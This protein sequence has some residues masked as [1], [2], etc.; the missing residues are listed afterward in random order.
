[1]LVGLV[2]LT[3]TVWVF[4][5]ALHTAVSG[6]ARH[7]GGG[8]AQAAIPPLGLGTPGAGQAGPGAGSG[9]NGTPGQAHAAAAG[10]GSGAGAGTGIG[11][12]PGSGS[13]GSSTST[14]APT[15]GCSAG[16]GCPQPPAVLC[17]HGSAGDPDSRTTDDPLSP[18]CV[19]WDG[20]DNGGATAQGVTGHRES[21]CPDCIKVVLINADPTVDYNT[22]ASPGTNSPGSVLGYQDVDRTWRVL[23]QFFQSRLQTYGR[24]V[25]IIP[26]R[27]PAGEQGAALAH[28]IYS[29]FQPFAVMDYGMPAACSFTSTGPTW[30]SAY[31]QYGIEWFDFSDGTPLCTGNDPRFHYFPNSLLDVDTV[32]NG[33]PYFW[34]GQPSLEDI[35]DDG[36]S[37]LC[38]SI[39]G[40][41]D[42]TRTHP[43]TESQEPGL[44]GQ[45]RRVALGYDNLFWAGNG[46]TPGTSWIDSFKAAVG[47]RCGYQLDGPYQ[48]E[49]ATDY[50]GSGRPDI[51][52]RA[53]DAMYQDGDTSVVCLLCGRP[54]A[55]T[56]YDPLTAA[57]AQH[58]PA[59]FPEFLFVSG[60]EGDPY[61][62]QYAGCNVAD[63]T[64]TPVPPSY[65]TNPQTSF[66]KAV[67]IREMW[68]LPGYTAT[69]WFKAYAATDPTT[70]VGARTGFNTYEKLMQLFSAIQLAGPELT[71]AH[72]AAG[73][74]RRG[75]TFV[76]LYGWQ[77]RFG[78]DGAGAVTPAAG[79][80]PA[81]HAFLRGMNEVRWSQNGVPPGGEYIHVGVN[82]VGCYLVIDALQRF[83]D[84]VDSEHRV[85]RWPGYDD[86]DQPNARNPTAPQC[87][88]DLEGDVSG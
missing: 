48:L 49:D 51:S 39:L 28:D 61:S 25:E 18:P 26:F 32:R 35:R 78:P 69:W 6:P 58:T 54:Y 56:F 55:N 72:V 37:W 29:Q 68:Q 19:A 83:A 80:S 3:L 60:V 70:V 73:D 31:A 40:G 12:G 17:R 87:A 22:P 23:R 36:S 21:T 66:D 38:S 63:P 13:G 64:T 84:Q 57:E 24:T 65:C 74:P 7:A 27:P 47:A 62:A 8:G 9:Q 44:N 79:Y 67:G 42:P 75:A 4:P 81:H 16:P 77:R 14:P 71:P 20:S 2:A 76:G 33:I 34:S 1:M 59:Y 50:R 82:D 53:V 86:S 88:G 41:S 30:T 10:P 46:P 15:P 85:D 11:P 43:V 5:G 52:R 45:H